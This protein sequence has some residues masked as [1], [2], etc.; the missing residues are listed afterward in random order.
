M[1]NSPI[2]ASRSRSCH[3]IEIHRPPLNFFDISLIQ[4]IADALEE[5]DRDSEI[6]AV[7][8][9]RARQGVLR[10][11]QFQRSRT[12]GAGGAASA[13]AIPPTTRLDQQSLSG[14][15]AHLPQQEADRRR[16]AGRRDRRRAWACG[17][18]GFPR[19]LSGSTLRRQLHQAR[20]SSRLR[21]D[22]DAARTDRQKQRRADVLH[23]PPRHRRGSHSDG[24]RQRAAC[25]RTR[26]APKRS[27]SPAKSPN[28]RRSACSRPARPCVRASPTASGR[29]Q[30]RTRRTD[31]A[32]RNRRFQGRRQGHRRAPRCEF[33]GAVTFRP[34]F[35]ASAKRYHGKCTSATPE[36]R[37][38]GPGCGASRT[39]KPFLTTSASTMV[40]PCLPDAP[41]PD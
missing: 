40:T 2:S 21:P 22:G 27:S 12:A 3:V 10:R 13:R 19:H 20:I 7:G 16:R 1:S 28:A 30:P 31:L 37:R 39:T 11:R 29:N 9:C 41:A 33:Q 32:A 14:S 15:G 6:R 8:A 17:V 24:P 26:C 4:Q 25:R 18:R 34:S 38:P 5:I 23:Q 35:R 36:Y